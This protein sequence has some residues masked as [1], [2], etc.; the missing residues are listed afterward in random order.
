MIVVDNYTNDSE[1]TAV[2]EVARV[3]G[4]TLEPSDN[5]GFG[6]GMNRGVKKAI[7]LGAEAL[8]LL[9]RMPLSIRTASKG[10]IRSCEPSP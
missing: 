4:W 7:E 6:A 1:R 3:H 9:T 8:L 2:G 10:F 5:V